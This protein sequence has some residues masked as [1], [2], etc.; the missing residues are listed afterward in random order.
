MVILS[1]GK[2]R[3]DKVNE[4]GEKEN[5]VERDEGGNERGVKQLQII[6]KK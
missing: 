2:H 3:G 6:K 5:K 4:E 1:V